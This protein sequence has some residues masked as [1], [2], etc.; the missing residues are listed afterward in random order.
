MVCKI[1]PL[2]A[3]VVNKIAAGEIII[4][5]VNALKEMMENS[6]DA[7]ASS[8]D[9]LVREGGI[10]LLQITDNGCG[11]SKEDLPILCQRF[12]TSKLA[13]FEDLEKIATYGFRGEALA[14]ISHIAR[15]TVTTKTREDRCAWRVS[16][17]DG[18]MIG[19]PKPAAGK[20][21]TVILVENLFYNM[22]SRLR[23]LRSSSEEYSKILDVV[24]RYACHSE[25]IAFSCKKF[26]DSQFALTVRAN[27]NSEERIRC[28]FGSEISSK[29]LSLEL[30]PLEK[31]GVQKVF[32]K[33][34][35]LDLS[36]KKSITPVFFINNRLVTCNP[37]ARA[38][39]QVYSN[40]LPK[41]DKPFM[42]LGIMINPEILDVNIHPTKREV[43]FLHEEEIIEAI[44]SKLNEEL[45]RIDTSR[46]FK[47]SSIVTQQP[48]KETFENTRISKGSVSKPPHTP[49][50]NKQSP[51]ANSARR[52]ENKL[53][54]TDASQSKI[55]SF[56]SN[57]S[58]PPVTLLPTQ[59]T[60]SESIQ[61]RKRIENTTE[62]SYIDSNG[63]TEV[64]NSPLRG[65]GSSSRG[66]K[67]VPKERVDVNLTSIKRLR[68]A[69]DGSAHKDLTDIFANMT[70]VGVVDE[71][72][73]L[74]TIQHDLKLFLLD[75]GAVCYELFYQ[76]CLTDFANFGI[77]NLQ[78]GSESG[79]NLVHILSH[80]E[81][82][83]KKSIKT[84]ITKIW[85][86]REMLSEYFS[87][88]IAG[89]ID[90]D[91]ENIQI[92]SAKIISIPLLLKGY[93]P[94]L[95]KLPFLIYRLGTKVDWEEEQPCLDGIMRQIA[96]LYV[97]EIIEHIDLEKHDT[98]E[99]TKA[100]FIEKTKELSVILDNV[101]FPC[102][103]KRFL[104]PRSLVKDTVEIANLP[105]LYRVFER[106]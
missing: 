7:G 98:P 52:Y 55:T 38:L 106:C 35:N 56:V 93:M 71:E 62:S 61:S 83:D 64:E 24:G 60:V 5:P 59:R 49:I 79:L 101:I 65:R 9:I 100:A 18:N 12:T 11:V 82:L 105:G 44:S 67:V 2:D 76:I 78:C 32:G 91:D 42:Y 96:L 31:F 103:K 95:S 50:Q 28:V 37:L 14:S 70:Y 30:G 20:D 21:G 45:S 102:I 94:P 22:P 47:T 86:M 29:L 16:F 15:V 34:S 19:E 40:Y 41:G 33:M 80:F 75:Y 87:I 72:R 84:I 104:A 43:R 58:T 17:A 3:S 51:L 90:S 10:K 85:E 27:L 99:N 63:T 89:N 13:K 6:I 73:R 46:T 66:Y 81:N 8:L 4:S 74:A 53:V 88:N 97:P 57:Q 36:F 92:E 48:L 54:R 23:A 77:I 39:R 26:G 69:V 68:E 1:K 25:G